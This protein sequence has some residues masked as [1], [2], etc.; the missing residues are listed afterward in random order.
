[1]D[2]TPRDDV[3]VIA[4]IDLDFTEGY[5]FEEQTR[6]QIFSFP[7]G[8]HY[9]YDVFASVIAPYVHT[10]WQ[11]LDRLRVIAG[12]RAEY[13]HYNYDNNTDVK[14]TADGTDR[15]IRPDD[16]VDDFLTVTPKLGFVYDLTDVSTAFVNFARGARAPQTTDLYRVQRG[17]L[18]GDADPERMDSVEV[19][20]RGRWGPV[21]GQI[22]GFFM[23]KRN[24]FF[25]DAQGFNETNGKTRHVGVEAETTVRLLDTLTFSGSATYARHTY[26]FDRPIT[27]NT[28][29]VSFGDDVDTAPRT[30]SNARL[31]WEP[32]EGSLVELEWQHMGR[33]SMDASN[34]VF[35]PGHETLSLRAEQQITTHA[36]LFFVA[37]NL[38]NTDYAERA[39]FAFGNERYFPGEDRGFSGGFRIRF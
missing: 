3:E 26:R 23:K 15:F 21:T 39:D 38:T 10:E 28:E 12:L 11:A 37:R 17:Q 7:P 22:A 24:F 27:G 9:D 14:L 34:S 1:V 36:Q 16:R 5:L 18:P 8:V 30:I 25:R 31:I 33:Y 29:S 35:Y 6:S 2:W 32:L 4:G 20:L 19:G 13:T